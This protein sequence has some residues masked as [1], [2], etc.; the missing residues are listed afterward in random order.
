MG[1]GVIWDELSQGELVPHLAT[2]LC[3]EPPY[4]A[5]HYR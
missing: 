1:F 4:E 2:I 5:G 3:V